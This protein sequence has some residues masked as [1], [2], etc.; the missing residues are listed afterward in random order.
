MKGRWVVGKKV[1]GRWAGGTGWGRCSG[2]GYG[3]V[4]EGAMAHRRPEQ[5]TTLKNKRVRAIP[6]LLPC[7]FPLT[8]STLE[9]MPR[10]FM[11]HICSRLL[12]KRQAGSF[13][14]FICCCYAAPIYASE[15]SYDNIMVGCYLMAREPSFH[16]TIP[17]IR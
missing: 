2:W 17:P 13:E 10:Y 5:D 14:E 16:A 9:Y 15:T 8:R 4:Q 6:H 7:F 11:K 1:V 3:E 12:K